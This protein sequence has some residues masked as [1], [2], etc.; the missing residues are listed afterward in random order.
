MN[1]DLNPERVDDH[2]PSDDIWILISKIFEE[3]FPR[4][5]QSRNELDLLSNEIRPTNIINN[6]S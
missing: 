1:V 6:P 2:S 4:Y 5:Q 3:Y